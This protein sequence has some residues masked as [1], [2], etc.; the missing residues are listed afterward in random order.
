MTTR[1]RTVLIVLGLIA[2]LGAVW[3][4]L[5]SPERKKASALD[6]QVASAQQQ[7]SSA[8]GSLAAARTAE[9]QYPAAYASI[10][11]LGKAVPTSA[12]VPSLI[13]E[14]ERASNNKKV[15]FASITATA[16]SGS[17]SPSGAAGSAAGTSTGTAS[18]AAA[19]AT[20]AGFSQMPF[21]VVFNGSFFD[22]EHLFGTLDG[23]ARRGSSGTLRVNGRL[24]TIQSVKLAPLGSGST[25]PGAS[26]PAAATQLT[27]T[28]AAT[29]YVLPA[30]GTPAAGSPAGSSSPAPAASSGAGGSPTPPAVVT[31]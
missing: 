6:G 25:S 7:L 12:E 18:T 28:I 9:A 21:T 15:E 11:S 23:F 22:L 26:G 16:T 5:V 10:A 14:L 30:Q 19:Q 3:V 1:D 2:V 24:L 31:R 13:Y 29:A 27:G 17:A 8:E 20:A 4:L